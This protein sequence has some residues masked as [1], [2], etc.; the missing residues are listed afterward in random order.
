MERLKKRWEGEHD[1]FINKNP[2][3][4]P[5]ERGFNHHSK[6]GTMDCNYEAPFKFSHKLSR[7]LK[8]KFG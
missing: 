4:P 8:Q 5:C 7:S 1:K 2:F 3:L 6:K